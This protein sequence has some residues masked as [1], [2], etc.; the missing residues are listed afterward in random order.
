MVLFSIILFLFIFKLF[1][2]TAWSILNAI[3]S[4]IELNIEGVNVNAIELEMGVL[5]TPFFSF[6]LWMLEI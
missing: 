1:K 3:L 2:N 4:E 5:C 6:Q